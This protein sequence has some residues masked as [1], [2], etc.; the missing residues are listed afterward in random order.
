GLLAPGH[1]GS[2][3][4]AEER[5]TGRQFLPGHDACLYHPGLQHDKPTFVIG[6]REVMDGVHALD[7]VA[8]TD[9]GGK[10]GRGD[11]VDAEDPSFPCLMED[12][13]IFFTPYRAEA[14]HATQVVDAVHWLM[15]PFQNRDSR[16]HHYTSHP[17]GRG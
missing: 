14:V 12:G 8:E 2:G 10:L 15:T 3:M 16:Q 1:G 13:F 5:G 6:G 7:G 11:E 9:N 4:V 17:A